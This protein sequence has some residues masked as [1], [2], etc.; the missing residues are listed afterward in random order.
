MSNSGRKINYSIRPAKSI[1]RKMMRDVFSCLR[2]HAPLRDY[3]YI[4]FGSKYFV[5]FSL[6]HRHLGIENLISI[7]A[8]TTNIERYEFNKPY[9]SIQMKFGKSTEILPQLSAQPG[10]K[11]YWLDYDGTF[12]PYMLDD[13]AIIAGTIESGS[14]Y[15]AS[16]NCSPLISGSHQND[17]SEDIESKLV[18][19]VGKPY[20]QPGIDTRGW[21]QSKRLAIFL[22]EC[23]KKEMQK[24]ITIRNTALPPEERIIIDQVLFFRYADGCEMATIAFT[25]YKESDTQIHSACRFNE[26]YFHRSGDSPF[27]IKTPNLTIKEIRHIMETMPDREKLSKKIFTDN[28]IDA[29]WDNYRYFPNFTEVEST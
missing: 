26:L 7:E 28:D 6:F 12:S 29:L 17:P 8:D 21:K 3:Q 24:I 11:I 16:F 14:I 4:G 23:L 5:D 25:F 22:K 18:D 13:A 10:R 2:H 15:S 9:S 19:L 27:E 1:E 20:V